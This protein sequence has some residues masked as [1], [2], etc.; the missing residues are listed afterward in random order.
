MVQANAKKR[1]T[2]IQVV[3]AV[4][5]A[6]GIAW[7]VYKVVG[8]NQAQQIYH[9]MQTAYAS[10]T[11]DGDHTS[12]NF[13]KLKAEY[14]GTTAWLKM[15][16]VD[17]SYPIMQGEDNDFYLHNDP[18]NQPNIDG[19]IF[20]DYRNKSYNDL[21]V[22]IYGH[23]MRDESMFGQLDEYVNEEFYRNGTGAFTIFTPE[24][25]YRYKI[26]A[27]NIVNET[28]D[29]YQTGYQNTTVFGGFAKQLKDRSMYD[30]GVDVTGNDHIVTLSTCSAYD[31]LVI[32]AKRV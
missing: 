6:V 3:L 11:V 28:D 2:I 22:L 13:D 26:F 7:L 5:V 9:E 15:D 24:A 25:T 23:N 19:S 8:Y 17:I 16:D 18:T 29:V 30:T 12:I 10:E 21:H 4:L 32:S 27:V 14:P 1:I 20:L 31:R